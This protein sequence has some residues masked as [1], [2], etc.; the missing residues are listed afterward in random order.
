MVTIQEA[1]ERW[2]VSGRTIR[3]RLAKGVSGASRTPDGQWL[4]PTSWLDQEFRE[5]SSTITLSEPVIDSVIDNPEPVIDSVIDTPRTPEERKSARVIAEETAA[6]MAKQRA[7]ADEIRDRR[8][9]AR[10]A[11]EAGTM[12]P[13]I[14]TTPD[15][16]YDTRSDMAAQLK[17]RE[18]RI[19]HLRDQVADL[20]VE[21]AGTTVDLRYAQIAEKRVTAE[22]DRANSDL[23]QTRS[24]LERI[25]A[26][27][28]EESSS[29]KA[30]NAAAETTVND[31]EAEI[32][33]LRNKMSELRKDLA[34]SRGEARLKYRR[35]RRKDQKRAAKAKRKAGE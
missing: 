15:M 9:A 6:E 14:D 35:Q 28:I 19:D 13:V 17:A 5:A 20:R 21:M 24:E 27:L 4:V 26:D 30:E 23:E 34:L 25:R 18:D 29:R 33:R 16:S 3:R 8:A 31:K 2:E 22:R 10:Q 11:R 7:E 32:E 1:E 12:T